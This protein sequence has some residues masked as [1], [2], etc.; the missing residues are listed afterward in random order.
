MSQ[1]HSVVIC[2]D[3]GIVREGIKQ[4]LASNP[5]LEVVGEAANGLEG[6]ALISKLR[7]DVVVTDITMPEMNGIDMTRE[8]T[9]EF[10]DIRVVILSVHSRKTFI[11]EA[12]KAGARGYVL[13]DSAG[14]KLLDAVQAVLDG[15]SYLDS[16]VAGHI[17]DEF[18][19]MPSASE[20]AAGGGGETLT[21][22]ERQIL[23][24]VVEGFSNKQI[25][26]KLFLSPK[27]VDN[28]RAKIM[29]KL[30]R[31][32]VIG[33]V[34]YALATGLVDPDTWGR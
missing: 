28:H 18:V 24:L 30:G 33:L 20:P 16:P 13:K 6:L 34:K 1:K 23:S 5:A 21:D 3:H 15:D 12:L 10:P 11:M 32:D 22:R 8:L 26:E 7:P 4:V 2:D 25:A 17:V 29:S 27:T 14:E 19:K 9:K 31:R